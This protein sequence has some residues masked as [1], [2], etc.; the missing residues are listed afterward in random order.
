[1]GFVWTSHPKKLIYNPPW[2]NITMNKM[3]NQQA[4][5]GERSRADAKLESCAPL[6]KILNCCRGRKCGLTFRP[7]WYEN[8]TP[9]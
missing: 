2:P 8:T 6:D 9:P 5:A 7:I 4:L 3:L 1:M